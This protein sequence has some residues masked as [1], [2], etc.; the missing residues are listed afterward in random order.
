M[1]TTDNDIR[2]F[3]VEV[4]AEVI[5]PRDEKIRLLTIAFERAMA[6]FGE[7]PLAA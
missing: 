7:E 2:E 3:P 4:L 6:E 5:D 1:D